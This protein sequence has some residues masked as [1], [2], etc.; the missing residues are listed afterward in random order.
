MNIILN[1][2]STLSIYEQIIKSIKNSI[3]KEEIIPGDMLPSIRSLARDLGISVI[4]TKRA[5]EELEKEDLIYSVQG[6]GF[7]VKE[8]NKE[9]LKEQQLKS[10]E[11]MAEK[12]IEEGRDL[13]LTLD[14]MQDVLRTL[15][16]GG[17]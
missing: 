4:T 11:I 14:D 10:F 13:G 6:K 8:P 17:N 9:K 1:S 16:E 2:E 3:V 5:Y 12:L 15:Y 7:Y